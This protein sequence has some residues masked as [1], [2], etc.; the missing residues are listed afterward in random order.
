MEE[1]KKSGL[2]TA[3]L[4]LGIVGVCLSFI[5]IINNAAFA[6]GALAVVFG[7]ITLIKK[8]AVGKC[9]AALILGVLAIVITIVMQSSVSKAIDDLSS[10]LNNITGDNTQEILDNDVEIKI[11]E[12]TVDDSGLFTETKLTV[13]VKNK[14]DKKHSFSIQIEAVNGDGTRIDSDYIYANDLGAG[15]DQNFDIF[16]LVTSDKIE[17]IKGASFNIVDISMF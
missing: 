13:N 11:G 1:T 7:I 12:F 9:V 10:E 2:G 6:L 5:P 8:A 4:V 17:E 16:T 15:Q 3:A 14:S